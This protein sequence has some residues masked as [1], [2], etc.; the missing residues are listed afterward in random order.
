MKELI[1]ITTNENKEQLVSGRELH[2]FLGATE[3][4]SNWFSR[5]LKYG[6][7]ENVDF[8]GCKVFNAQAKQE[9][10]D[11]VI[12][13]DMA[14]EISMI[15]RTDKGRQARKYFIQV[16]KEL[17]QQHKLPT[18]SR[19][20]AKLAL[21]ANEETNERLD[22]IDIR[23]IDIEENKLISTEDANALNRLVRSKV[24]SV[25]KMMNIDKKAKA[26]LFADIGKSIKEVFD[27][28]HRGRIKDKDYL[29]ACD[30]IREWEPSSV[31]NEKIKQLRKELSNNATD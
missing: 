12:S 15:Q 19:E 24:Y 14:K 4:Y 2:E 3:R 20:L 27:V 23:L 21:E 10:Q 8:V 9:L 6:F 22:D 31:T 18:T 26:L 29:R 5:M 11:H 7:T 17:R 1:K 25:W 16:E 13:L 28:P 30:F